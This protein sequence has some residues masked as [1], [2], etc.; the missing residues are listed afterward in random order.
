MP[1]SASASKC[2][3]LTSIRQVENELELKESYLLADNYMAPCECRGNY[4]L[5]SELVLYFTGELGNLL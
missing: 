4:V 2:A 1:F 3:P 5:S